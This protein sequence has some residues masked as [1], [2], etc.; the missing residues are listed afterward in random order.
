M[1]T[2]WYGRA[3]VAAL[4][5]GMAWAGLRALQTPP[6]LQL[7]IVVD[8]LR[9]DQVTTAQMPRL[10]AIATRGIRFTAH[11][12]VF[13]TVT[14]VN[15]ATF[16]TGVLPARHGLLGNTIYIRRSIRCGR[17]TPPTTRRSSKW[18]P[19]RGPC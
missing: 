15:A 9:P 3:L 18:R 17:S 6:R 8:G 10:H 16:V 12:A 14:R 19:Q 7:V 2:R 1:T 4:V 13:P 11:H 5:V